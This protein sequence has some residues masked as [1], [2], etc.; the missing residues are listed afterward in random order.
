[1]LSSYPAVFLGMLLEGWAGR[2]IYFLWAGV[3]L[4]AGIGLLKWRRWAL[5]MTI[6]I[7]AF[8][9]LNTRLSL[10]TGAVTRLNE[11]IQERMSPTPYPVYPASSSLMF[12]MIIAVAFLLVVF[13]ILITRRRAFI[14]A[15]ETPATT[16]S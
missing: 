6:G 9:L 13:W 16:T 12:T 7:Y 1:L 10:M 14:A 11:L 2:S 8:G 3:S 5:A 4:V 15:C